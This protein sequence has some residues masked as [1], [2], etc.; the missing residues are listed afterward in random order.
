MQTK[1]VAKTDN[2]S[3]ISYQKPEIQLGWA[4]IKQN[5]VRKVPKRD[6][7]NMVLASVARAYA[8]LNIKAIS[9]EERDYLVNELTGNIIAR[10]PAIRVSEIPEAIARGIRGKYGEYYGLSVVSFEKLLS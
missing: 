4:I 2:K 1:T 9:A 10:Y 8:D 7:F 6:V 3:E 5:P